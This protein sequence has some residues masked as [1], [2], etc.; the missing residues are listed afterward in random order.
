[1]HKKNEEQLG[2]NKALITIKKQQVKINIKA[3]AACKN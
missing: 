3:V 1:M 2:R